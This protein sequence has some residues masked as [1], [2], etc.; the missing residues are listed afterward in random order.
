MA[1]IED[2]VY[3]ELNGNGLEENQEAFSKLIAK[4]QDIFTRENFL[5][6]IYI[7]KDLEGSITGKLTNG[8]ELHFFFEKVDYCDYVQGIGFDL[9]SFSF[10][11]ETKDK[12]VL[13][14]EYQFNPPKTGSIYL[15]FRSLNFRI[16]AKID[17][18]F[19]Y[20]DLVYDG[21][22]DYNP[23]ESI[24]DIE[25]I[26]SEMIFETLELSD[27]CKSMINFNT[28]LK[29]I[30]DEFEKEWFEDACEELDSL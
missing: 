1:I 26:T 27:F 7:D 22:V 18:S 13:R 11:Y 19:H 15:E 25:T 9:D 12:K 21:D 29:G 20:N 24:H 28:R 30:L 4:W 23:N 3:F 8:N 10:S 6:D 17:I 2:D 16:D 5:D 14:F